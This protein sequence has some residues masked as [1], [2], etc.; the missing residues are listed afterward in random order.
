VRRLGQDIA[1]G[2]AFLWGH[3]GLRTVTVIGVLQSASFGGLLAVL[4]PWSDQVLR[5]GTSGWRFSMLYTAWGIGA[6]A[7]SAAMGRVLRSVSALRLTLLATPVSAGLAVVVSLMTSWWAAALAVL[8]WSVAST[9][10]SIGLVSYR[11][12]ATPEPLLGR[13]NTT[14][15]M[16]SWGIGGTVGALVAGAVAGLAGVRPTIVAA[17]CSA[18]LAATVAWISPLRHDA[19]RV[20]SRGPR[21]AG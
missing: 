18:L 16:L 21:R 8:M 7:A 3:A 12:E 11:Q 2:L 6:L 4:V 17:A 5:I 9:G 19:A 14:G 1:E 15:R 13:V 20:S 10:V